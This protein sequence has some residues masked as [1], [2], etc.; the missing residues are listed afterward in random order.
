[1]PTEAIAT[2]ISKKL[3]RPLASPLQQ[4]KDLQ[5]WPRTLLVE[6]N[7]I[8]LKIL[9]MLIKKLGYPYETA[10]DGLQ[11][12]QAYKA[13]K[14]AYD[15]IL[16]DIQM[17]VMDGMQASQHIREYEKERDMAP[18]TI[19]ALTGLGSS[20]VRDQALEMGIDMLLTKPVPMKVLKSIIDNL[21]PRHGNGVDKG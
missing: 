8:N 21:R 15:V 7:T 9:I 11:A 16:M 14:G 3:A 5:S 10:N 20:E 6:D 2:V 4:N 19:V 17:P 18:T 13:A 1:M 12:L